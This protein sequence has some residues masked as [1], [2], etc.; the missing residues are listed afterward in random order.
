[1]AK[2][3]TIFKQFIKMKACQPFTN[4]TF[5]FRAMSQILNIELDG[6]NPA[7]SS[8]RT[9][10]NSL[11]VVFCDKEPRLCFRTPYKKSKAKLKNPLFSF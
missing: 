5:V 11:L 4:K 10:S 6:K 8:F 3:G 9:F 2:T 1:M 7:E